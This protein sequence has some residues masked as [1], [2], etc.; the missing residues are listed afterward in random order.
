MERFCE[1][2]GTL[3]SGDGKFCPNCGAVLESAVNLS[4][5]DMSAGQ[6]PFADPMPTPVQNN[7]YGTSPYTPTD[8]YNQT[9]S[10]RYSGSSSSEYGSPL[11]SQNYNTSPSTE[12][13]MTVGQW[14]GTI[15]LVTCIP[16]VSL[17]LLFLWAFGDAPT[18]K[19]NFCRAYLIVAAIGIGISVVLCIGMVVCSASLSGVLDNYYY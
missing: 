17:V 1:N 3:V 14:V 19:K 11:Y 18:E 2:C 5:P 4:K 12:D 16:V 15:L 6:A 9:D 8:S 10:G 13:H 7:T